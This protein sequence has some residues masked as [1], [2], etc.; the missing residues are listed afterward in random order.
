MPHNRLY[1]ITDTISIARQQSQPSTYARRTW[2]IYCGFSAP[3]HGLNLTC[4]LRQGRQLRYGRS[5]T[6]AGCECPFRPPRENDASNPPGLTVA[7]TATR[8]A[9]AKR[10]LSYLIHLY[11]SFV[12]GFS[13][14]KRFYPAV[15]CAM[16]GPYR[17]RP[18]P[19]RVT[20]AF[21]FIHRLDGSYLPCSPL[22]KTRDR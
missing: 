10:V 16:R 2:Q 21:L 18:H 13:P 17:P 6:V 9:E 7:S 1:T 3:A 15:A 11:N 22:R 19:F 8:L 20:P 12:V 5:D 4:A 14:K